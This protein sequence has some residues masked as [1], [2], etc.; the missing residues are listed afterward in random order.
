[1]QFNGEKRKMVCRFL[2]CLIESGGF[3][4]FMMTRNEVAD[5]VKGWCSTQI[6]E[7]CEK[8]WAKCL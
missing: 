4:L 3:S 2:G 6:E 8:V 1:M 7:M 5:S